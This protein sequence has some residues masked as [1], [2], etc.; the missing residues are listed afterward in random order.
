MA[1]IVGGTAEVMVL[2]AAKVRK[3]SNSMMFWVFWRLD[4]EVMLD[5]VSDALRQLRTTTR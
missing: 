5:M 3:L 4:G 1:A 2:E